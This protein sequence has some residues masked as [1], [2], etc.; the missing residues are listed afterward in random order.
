MADKAIKLK[1]FYRGD[2]P[3]FVVPVTVSNVVADL[4][5]Y[6]GY[7]TFTTNTDPLTNADA[8]LHATMTTSVADDLGLGYSGYFYYQFT[9]TDTENFDP[10]SLYNWDVQINKAPENTNNF[11][12]ASGT[13]QPRTDYSRGLS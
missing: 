6:T 9:N 13:F 3:L 4:T 10:N 12:I 5:D 11:T 7:I 2:T 8:F 1:S